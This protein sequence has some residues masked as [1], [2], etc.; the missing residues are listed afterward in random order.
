[1]N[2]N[3][4]LLIKKYTNKQE[5]TK[6]LI[7]KPHM[8]PN[9]EVLF[10][11]YL[12]KATNY[13]EFGSGGSTYQAANRIN[14]K[15]IYS[16]ESDMEWHNKLKEIL[17]DYKNI[18]FIYNEMDTKPNTWGHPGPNSTEEQCKNY[19]NQ[20]LL[21]D[22]SISKNLDLILIDG[23]FRIACCLK[24]FD[25]INDDCIIIFDDFL[26]RDF[27]I[28][29]NY[30]TIINQTKDKRMVILKKK[31]NCSIPHELIQKFELVRD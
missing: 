20:I 23:R 22:K 30:Y 17:K 7:I 4:L 27:K 6:Q 25:M 14:I 26:N 3:K 9:D 10:Y 15:N 12:N 29:L 24:C 19:S 13:F 18:N 16:I 28:V 1:M 11:K 5:I 2:N 31:L 21:L 8:G